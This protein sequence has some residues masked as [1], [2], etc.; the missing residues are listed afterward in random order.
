P[1]GGQGAAPFRDV[2]FVLVPEVLE[3]GQHRRDGS[4]TKRAERLAGDVPGNARQQIEIA[5]LTPTTFDLPQNLVEP[6]R[7]LAAR[8]AFAAR[9][10]AIEVQ[11]V[12][13]EPDHAGRVVERDDA[14]RAEERA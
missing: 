1:V 11:Q 4:V 6:V 8:G 5:H 3:R 2:R 12:F 9:F 10:V 13:G 14:G 7:A